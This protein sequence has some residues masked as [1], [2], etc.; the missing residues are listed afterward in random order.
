MVVVSVVIDFDV[1]AEDAFEGGDPAASLIFVPDGIV[2]V[3]EFFE[4]EF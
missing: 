1:E 4:K 2:K 3:G